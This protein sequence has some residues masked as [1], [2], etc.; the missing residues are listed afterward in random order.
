MAR[1]KYDGSSDVTVTGRGFILGGAALL[2]AILVA[3]LLV[4]GWQAGWWFRAQNVNRSAAI[5][6][7]S[8]AFQQAKV[9]ELTRKRADLK[10]LKATAATTQDADQQTQ[11]NAQVA[12]ITSIIC[13]DFAQLA[14]SYR[15]TLDPATIVDVTALCG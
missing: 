11:L 5:N 15:D 2:A 12:A 4:G 14:P 8:L 3:L 9:D 13:A 6:R 1:L 10:T 7:Q